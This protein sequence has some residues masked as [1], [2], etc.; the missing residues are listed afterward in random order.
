[1]S[2]NLLGRDENLNVVMP[3]FET[4][5]EAIATMISE[6]S[7]PIHTLNVSNESFLLLN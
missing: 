6:G 7:C 5:A 1:M 4:G 2:K 3:S